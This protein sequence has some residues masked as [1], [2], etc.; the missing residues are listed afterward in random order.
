MLNT[1]SAIMDNKGRVA[2]WQ[3]TNYTAL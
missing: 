2:P 3:T 1:K